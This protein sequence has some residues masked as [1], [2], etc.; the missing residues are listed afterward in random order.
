M[1]SREMTI[2]KFEGITI[3]FGT[4]DLHVEI[5]SFQIINKISD[6]LMKIKSTIHAPLK[7]NQTVLKWMHGDRNELCDRT[8]KPWF[9]VMS[10]PAIDKSLNSSSFRQIAYGPWTNAADAKNATK[11]FAAHKFQWHG[12]NKE[13]KMVKK[14]FLCMQSSWE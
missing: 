1:Y 6:H 8:A 5:F 10:S 4:I 14:C 13:T 12:Q 9:R 3:R 2:N 11:F 7:W